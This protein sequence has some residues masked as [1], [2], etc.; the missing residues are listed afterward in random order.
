MKTAFSTLG[1]P[2]WTWEEIT[3]TAA[4]LGFD[5]I[6]VRGIGRDM[7]M[8]GAKIFQP[9]NI[10]LT[11]KRLANLNIVISCFA[12]DVHLNERFKIEDHL[13]T[14]CEYIDLADLLGVRY[15]RVLC[16][17]TPA[18][19]AKIDFGGIVES[20]KTLTK[21]A[22]QKGVTVLVETNGAFADSYQMLKLMNKVNSSNLGVIWDIHHPYFYFNENIEETYGILKPYIRSLHIKDAWV[23]QDVSSKYTMIGHGNL[24]IKEILLLLKEDGYDGYLTLEWLKRWCGNLAEAGIVFPQYLAYINDVLK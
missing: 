21:Y 11:K 7:Y 2:Q 13:A 14:A 19:Q 4:D 23:E 16:E 10:E 8:P 24:P 20:L 22:S 12:T 18:P 15:V 5:G 1:C 17:N 3:V 6:E 9:E